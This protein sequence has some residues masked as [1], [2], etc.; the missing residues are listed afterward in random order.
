MNILFIIKNKADATLKFILD[1]SR[2]NA[3][4]T[5]IELKKNHE[6]NFII[7]QIASCDK[8]ISW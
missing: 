8:V 1:E 5:V 7:E 4:V 6:Y 3:A 2:K